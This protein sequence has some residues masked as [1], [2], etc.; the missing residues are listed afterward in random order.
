[1]QLDTK[2]FN[3]ILI[4]VYLPFYNT[5]DLDS[6]TSMYRETMGFVDHIMND[7]VGCQFIILADLNCNIYDNRHPYTQIVR[8]VM[9]NYD[10]FPCFDLIPNFDHNSEFTRFDTK[11]NSTHLLIAY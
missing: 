5:R 4:N 3:I 7:N 2:S 10:L 1:M 8:S 6:Y 11:T 9:E